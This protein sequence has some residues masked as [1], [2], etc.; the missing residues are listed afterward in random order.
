MAEST[1]YSRVHMHELCALL[2]YSSQD[3]PNSDWIV[4]A[5]VDRQRR[6]NEDYTRDRSELL[7]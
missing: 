2:I 6:E 4:D 7:G 1:E 3:V 5:E